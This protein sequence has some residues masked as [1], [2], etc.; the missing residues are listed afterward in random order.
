MRKRVCVPMIALC[1]L[2]SGCG[3]EQEEKDLREPYRSMIGCTMEA[4]VSCDQEGYVWEAALRCDYVPDGESSLEILE[5]ET[6]AGVRAVVSDADWRLEYEELCLDMGTISRE[7]I[8]PVM[9]LPRLMDALRE[10][11]LLEE[12]EENWVET[13]CLR[14]TVDQTGE[15]KGKI[16]STLWLRLEDGLPVRGEISV[17]DEIILTAEFTNFT[18]CD[19]IN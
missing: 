2:L 10:G 13:P 1:L 19:I 4:V 9:C 5:P 12:N 14:L 8:S 3:A 7:E 6:L 18:F 11:W 15:N 16:L 17:E